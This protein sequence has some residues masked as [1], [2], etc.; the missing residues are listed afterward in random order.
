MR[1]NKSFVSMRSIR[2]E[3]LDPLKHLQAVTTV[4]NTRRAAA[5]LDAV[6]TAILQSSLGFDPTGDRAFK[7]EL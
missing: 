3:I 4:K 7:G 2:V 1:R 6:L 5:E